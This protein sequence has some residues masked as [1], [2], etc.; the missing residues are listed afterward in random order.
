[1][2]FA[3]EVFKKYFWVAKLAFVALLASESA[4]LVNTG[5]EARIAEAADIDVQAPPRASRSSY[6]SVKEFIPIL[7]RNLFNSD[8][9]YIEGALTGTQAAVPVDYELIGTI[10][11]ED[12]PFS[13]AII[14]NRLDGRSDVY[15][16]GD[17]LSE[18]VTLESVEPK[19]ATI[20]RQGVPE[21]L[22][23]V[24]MRVAPSGPRFGK[25]VNLGKDGIKE[26]GEGQYVVSK[27]LFQ[28]TFSHPARMMRGVRVVPHFERGR[29]A[30]FRF[31]RI[32]KKSL[33]H[34][35]GLRRKDILRR[36]NGIEISGVDD[37]MKVM[38]S[39]REA[40]RFT[41]DLTRKGQK[42]S[43]TYEVR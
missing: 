8:Y 36:I 12:E 34:K 13:M 42:R 17:A 15:G 35:I 24:E 30:G 31:K 4:A 37:I 11:F 2:S 29:I 6:V 3:A 38:A 22:K 5:I 7:E 19:Q 28:E 21:V 16:I 32:R 18:N 25:D 26:V 39:L 10:A 1:M 14:N 20:R 33:Y 43:F 40:R 27:D 9:E 23:L 41:I